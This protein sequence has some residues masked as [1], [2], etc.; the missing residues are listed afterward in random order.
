MS[1]CD[2]CYA[3][4]IILVFIILFLLYIIGNMENKWL[5]GMWS[6]TSEYASE[7][8]IDTMI[9]YIA[10]NYK[11][12]FLFISSGGEII[13]E[14][15]FVITSQKKLPA[16]DMKFIMK[17]NMDNNIWPEEIILEKKN[18]NLVVYNNDKVILGLF[19]KEM[20]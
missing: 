9:L 5:K 6:V 20:M 8:D 17:I 16:S 13:C 2:F 10:E 3:V 12:G 14:E 7:A 11:T 19:R 18:N 1:E 15:P 4:M